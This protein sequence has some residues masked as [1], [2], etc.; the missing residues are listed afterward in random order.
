MK[1]IS[2]IGFWK[3]PVRL[4]KEQYLGK[5]KDHISTPKEQQIIGFIIAKSVIAVGVIQPGG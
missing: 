2:L 3:E 4:G 1:N 5:E